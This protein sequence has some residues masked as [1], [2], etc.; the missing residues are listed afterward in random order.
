MDELAKRFGDLA[1]QYGPQ[2]V[3]AAKQAARVGAYSD[4][5]ISMVGF[6]IAAGLIFGGLA[7]RKAA[8]D[9]DDE[10]RIIGVLILGLG[11]LVSLV[12]LWIW[13]DPWTWTAIYHPEVWIAKK[14]LGL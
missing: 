5:V 6:C 10:Y 13:I 9:K 8:E 11:A 3:D 12:S 14:T 1:V 2:V 4:L 7:L